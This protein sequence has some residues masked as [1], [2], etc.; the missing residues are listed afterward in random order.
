MTAIVIYA[1]YSSNTQSEQS[2][3]GQLKVCYEYAERNGY[4]VIAEYIGRAIP[5][6]LLLFSYILFA[7]NYYC[8]IIF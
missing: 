4:K 8:S 1:R 7:T 2:I 5:D 6:Y 3:E